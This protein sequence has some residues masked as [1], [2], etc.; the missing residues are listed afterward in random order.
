MLYCGDVT[1]VNDG[2]GRFTTLPSGDIRVEF[3][4]FP[5]DPA[6]ETQIWVLDD[7]TNG[8]D[9]FT[10]VYTPDQFGAHWF[11]TATV[12]AN[13]IAYTAC[14]VRH[15]FFVGPQPGSTTTSTT[16][17]TTAPDSTTIPAG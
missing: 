5:H 15:D 4:P 13:T 10:K 1:E 8:H 9:A 7:S 12:N 11:D 17:T 6:T 3:G 14:P 16:T 2:N